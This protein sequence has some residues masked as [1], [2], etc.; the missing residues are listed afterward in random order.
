MDKKNIRDY[1]IAT[2]LIFFIVI[3]LVFC[4]LFLALPPDKFS[5]EILFSRDNIKKAIFLI[6]VSIV[7]SIAVT[8]L[9]KPEE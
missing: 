9:K 2:C 7:I 1:I 6:I 3:V 8:L 4:L 5:L